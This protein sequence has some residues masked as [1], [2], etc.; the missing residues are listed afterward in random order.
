MTQYRGVLNSWS[1]PTPHLKRDDGLHYNERVKKAYF[2]P[3]S[4]NFAGSSFS[5]FLHAR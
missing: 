3:L 2:V 5:V 4:R 1:I